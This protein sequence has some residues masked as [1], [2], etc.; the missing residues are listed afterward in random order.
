MDIFSHI[1]WAYV[2]FRNKLWRDEG[3]FFA[4]LPD[5]GF[6]LIILYVVLGTPTLVGFPQALPKMPDVLLI[7]YFT[8]HS[9]V[10]LGVVALIVWKFKPKLLPAL[11]GWF[12]HIYRASA[13]WITGFLPSVI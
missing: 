6:L 8:L 12:L 4:V 9:F 3:L 7:I 10:T 5:F 1:L 13:G 2:P 11:S